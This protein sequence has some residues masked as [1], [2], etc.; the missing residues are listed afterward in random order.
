MPAG[1]MVA[2]PLAGGAGGVPGSSRTVRRSPRCSPSWL[3]LPDL[4]T[5]RSTSLG[6]KP[7]RTSCFVGGR[8]VFWPSC[9]RKAATLEDGSTSLSVACPAGPLTLKDSIAAEGAD[10]DN[11]AL[12]V[13]K[14]HSGV[15]A[16]LL[17][18]GS[19]RS[20]CQNIDSRSSHRR[21]PPSCFALR[22]A[23][24]QLHSSS[25]SQR[26]GRV[27]RL[28]CRLA[29]AKTPDVVR[30]PRIVAPGLHPARQTCDERP[31]SSSKRPAGRHGSPLVRPRPL[32]IARRPRCAEGATPALGVHA[33]GGVPGGAGG[34]QAMQASTGPKPP[35]RGR[36]ILEPPTFKATGT[37]EVDA[38]AVVRRNFAT[39]GAGAGGRRVWA[40]GRRE[41][42]QPAMAP[43]RP[44][45]GTMWPGT[46]HCSA[47]PRPA[48][49]CHAVRP[50]SL[51]RPRATPGTLLATQPRCWLPPAASTTW[52]PLPSLLSSRPPRRR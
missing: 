20:L 46:E 28:S 8:P 38:A 33:G 30:E 15:C 18:S 31:S 11:S 40:A 44:H 10:V 3:K 12:A 35:R 24:Q 16:A 7:A 32:H 17:R 26:S 29:Y 13:V 36:V 41:R 47:L 23:P 6:G 51:P 4:S 39:A 14:C 49:P 50:S 34:T 1:A 9:S 45:V 19:R 25:E 27:C 21:L 42:P 5:G 52:S 22:R 2:P 48:L 37:E 43:P